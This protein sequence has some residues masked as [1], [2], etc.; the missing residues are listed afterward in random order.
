MG[1]DDFALQDLAT[2]LEVDPTDPLINS[3]AMIWGPEA[4]R[5][6][7]ASRVLGVEAAEPDHIA[8]AID[9][10][11]SSGQAAY[12]LRV[13]DRNRIHGW[14]VWRGDAIPQVEIQLGPETTD[15]SLEPDRGHRF[16]ALG[17]ATDL[18]LVAT[19][20]I[21][22]VRLIS[23]G[24]RVVGKFHGAQDPLPRRDS[25]RDPSRPE[26][27][28]PNHVQ[29][30][31]P[32]YADLEATRACLDSLERQ[33]ADIEIRTYIVDDCSPE[34]ALSAHLDARAARGGVTL[35]KNHRNL[36]FVGAVNEALELYQ[37]GDVLFVNADIV[38][39]PGAIERLRRAVYSAPEIGTAT[40][41]SNNG[42]FTS[43]PV[44]Y[45]SNPLPSIQEIESLD[46]RFA[47]ANDGV[48][49][50]IP[51]GIGFCLY[52]K[53]ECFEAVG[54]LSPL[55]APGYGEDIEFCLSAREKGFVNVCAA[56][57]F[58]G[59]AG[60]LSFRAAKRAYVV[61][62]LRVLHERFPDYRVE[63]AAFLNADPLR[64][65][66]ARVEREL[67]P[68]QS[69][70]LLFV[71]SCFLDEA[72]SE[73]IRSLSETNAPPSIIVMRP[74]VWRGKF[75]LRSVGSQMPQSLSF[76]IEDAADRVALSNYL[77]KINLDRIE[78]LGWGEA[79]RDLVDLL[80]SIGA[81]I[82]VLC[83]DSWPLRFRSERRDERCLSDS[84]GQPCAT[85]VRDAELSDLARAQVR[86]AHH[87]L[88]RT[89]DDASQFVTIDPLSRSF[90][91]HAFGN[92]PQRA[93]TF[94]TPSTP[95]SV[96][97]VAGRP[98]LGILA[99]TCSASVDNFLKTLGRSFAAAKSNTE[100]VVF[101]AC[102]D[103]LAI[104][105]AGS[106]FVTGAVS[107]EEYDRLL[108]QYCVGWLFSPY[109]TSH[110][111]LFNQRL[112]TSHLPKA[113]FDWSFGTVAQSQQDLA[114]DPR[115]CDA[116][117]SRALMDWLD[118]GGS[119]YETM[120]AGA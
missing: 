25:I 75:E 61:R 24:G 17:S 8:K 119:A 60:S 100:I 15:V 11:L 103:D 32:V 14:V 83:A 43:F 28:A 79:S 98:T 34:P 115:I 94:A 67:P 106:I 112:G 70:R 65:A 111:W 50:P 21:R 39:P 71:G 90:A 31:V 118:R 63:C 22:E 4:G 62:N 35:L 23:D 101:G 88:A 27:S 74:S 114:L 84:G 72:A 26:L 78:V 105:A 95:S 82:D 66:R 48:A 56:D 89:L 80:S 54:S 10:L 97:F 7:A 45:R 6:D 68:V 107:I 36:G 5:V 2:A 59:H 55:Y 51:N 116:K 42:E 30:I 102:L 81:T 20:A 96:A 64:D 16:A 1:L 18:A 117:A 92:W 73:R 58:V 108:V 110:F 109:R 52:V 85:C 47:G 19:A 53:R 76:D 113:Y 99:P 120:A 37:G 9:V 29:A 104:M 40:P 38:L 12:Q 93:A 69:T 44:P 33:T 41:F 77:R 91:G 13:V 46:R 49:I 3:A 87:L 86:E 57:V